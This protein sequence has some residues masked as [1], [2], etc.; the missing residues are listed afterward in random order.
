MVETFVQ[1]T[2]DV[3]NFLVGQH[4]LIKDMFDEVLSASGDEARHEAFIDL[5]QL[6]AV[7]ETA[8]EMIVHPRARG[9]LDGGD[10]IVDARLKEEH[11]AKAQLQELEK[12][13]IGS[14][15]FLNALKEVSAGGDP[16]RRPRGDRG[17]QPAATRDQRRRPQADGQCGA[18]GR[19]DRAHASSPRCRVGEGQLRGWTVRLDARSRARRHRKRPALTLRHGG[20]ANSSCVG[21]RW[22]QTTPAPWS[23]MATS[24]FSPC[25]GT[26]SSSACVTSSIAR[27]SRLPR[28][29]SGHR[30]LNEVYAGDQTID[31]RQGFSEAAAGISDPWKRCHDCGTRHERSL[32]LSGAYG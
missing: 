29:S 9:E 7:H 10:A 11:D 27:R 6:L 4:N 17:V 26:A 13:D 28:R 3:V 1:S 8:E 15:E 32:E 14:A 20:G 21:H 31:A 18:G 23:P 22:S 24:S 30:R 19:S 5:R 12:M 25:A 16:P 2:E